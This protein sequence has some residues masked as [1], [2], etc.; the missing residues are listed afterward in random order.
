MR[1]QFLPGL[2]FLTLIIFFHSVNTHALP[3]SERI[4][5]RLPEDTYFYFTIPNFKAATDL[6]TSPANQTL[7]Q[8]LKDPAMAEL[9]DEFQKEYEKASREIQQ[10]TGFA[11]STILNIPTGEASLAV[12]RSDSEKFGVVATM[13][14]GEGE[15]SGVLKKLLSA[16]SS[17]LVDQG[18]V[19]SIKRV[20]G[21]IFQVY[22]FENNAIDANQVPLRRELAYFHKD[23]TLVISN[24]STVLEEY[25][26]DWEGRR[27][28]NLAGKKEYQYI[29]Q[30]CALEN[31][32]ATWKWYMNPVDAIQSSLEIYS[33][34][35]P[36][37][38]MVQGVLP[39]LGIAN[40][41]AVGGS[42]Y[43]FTKDYQFVAKTFTYVKLPGFG[44]IDV[45]RCPAIPQKPPWWVTNRCMSYYSF[46][47]AIED[48]Y[49]AI[50][51]LHDGIRVNPGALAKAIDDYAEQEDSPQIHLKKDVLDS[52]SGRIQ[53]ITD[54]TDND[55]LEQLFGR[56][57]IALGLKEPEIFRKVILTLLDWSESTITSREFQGTTL[58]EYK[59]GLIPAAFCIV[60]DTF[61][62]SS[63]IEVIEK[64]IRHDSETDSLVKQKSYQK[65]TRSFPEETS[66]F[67]FQQ[68][69]AQFESLFQFLER[70]PVNLEENE[71][72]QEMRKQLEPRLKMMKHAMKYL[73]VIG[74]YSIPDE[75]GFFSTWFAIQA[76]DQ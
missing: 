58:Y 16:A 41:K 54:A 70:N 17:Y 67:W 13:E 11:L 48:A 74:G 75:R 5:R 72:T 30:K 71:E 43:F 6:W 62:A 63:N 1:K 56:Y 55:S 39:T 57:T 22:S 24:D 18:G 46:N 21:T 27:S 59:E 64:V 31:Q 35:E 8:F 38:G 3:A 65:L 68:S 76:V 44:L 26:R 34:S 25:C 36:M 47:W 52:L 29:L 32:T 51:A 69:K 9:R 60:D 19:R 61:I 14:Y 12:Y 45:F 23:N 37:A 28:N 2:F 42:A 50:E 73:P 40:L 4:A 53:I 10:Q 49:R 7:Q 33:R 20:E 15:E 66:T